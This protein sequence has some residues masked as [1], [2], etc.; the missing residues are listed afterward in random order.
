MLKRIKYI[1][2]FSKEYNPEEIDNL[3]KEAASN[4][5]KI[6]ITGILMASGSLFFQIIEGPPKE[7]DSLFKRILNDSRHENVMMLREEKG[8]P[9][10]L[11][12]DWSMRKVDLS[13]T[14]NMRLEPLNTILNTIYSQ[15]NTINEMAL[16]LEK[17]IWM[18]FVKSYQT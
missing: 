18:E 7:I 6:G 8:V 4:N 3:V 11:F 5:K 9:E 1:S 14:A 16:T 10:R 13:Q 15:Y 17:A 2:A 12:P